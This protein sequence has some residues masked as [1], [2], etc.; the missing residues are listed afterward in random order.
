MSA[1]EIIP[2]LWLGNIKA[3]LNEEFIAFNKITHVINCTRNFG[4]VQEPSITK[5]RIKVSDTGTEQATQEM[6][7]ILDKSIKYIYNKLL[8][9]HRVLVHC[10]AGKQRSVAIVAA[11]ISKYCNWSIQKSLEILE[12]KWGYMPDRYIEALKRWHTGHH[13]GRV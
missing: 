4:F 11:F 5:V 8:E 2:N 13:F 9:G 6:T 12:S 3:G 10:Y 7:E 1:I